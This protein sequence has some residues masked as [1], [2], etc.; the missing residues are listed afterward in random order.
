MTRLLKALLRSPA[1]TMLHAS[2]AVIIAGAIVTALTARDDMVILRQGEPVSVHG[3]ELELTEFRTI[4]YPDGPAPRNYESRLKVNGL[5]RTLAVNAPLTADDWR[6][7]QSSFTPDGCSVIAMRS[8]GPGTAIVFAGYALFALGGFLALVRRR[9]RLTALVAAAAF[10]I[11]A[12]Q[13]VP[14]VTHHA[15]DSLARIPVEYQGRTVTYST[16]AHE[17]MQKITGKKSFRGLSAERVVTS[18]TAFPDEWNAVPLIKSSRGLISFNDCFDAEGNYLL[19]DEPD[20]DE[21]VGIILLL[22]TG[23]LFAPAAEGASLPRADLEIL[24]NRTPSTLVIFIAFFVAAALC[25]MA[26]RARWPRW[27]GALPT[28]MQ[29]GVIAIQC[30]LTGHG[31]FASTFETLQFMVAAVGLLALVLPGSPGPAL[32]A[33]GCMALVAHLQ[34]SNPVVTPLMPVLHSPWLSLHVSLV[35]TSYAMLVVV[36]ATAVCGLLRNPDECRR[37]ARALLRP[38]VYLLGLGI[39]TGSVWA[40]QSWGRYWGWDPKETW[41][42]ITMLVYA[43]PLHRRRPSLWW[44]I[45]PLLSVAMTYFGVNYFHS[46]HAYS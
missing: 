11:G 18:M 3:I 37:R 36:A 34:A 27:L 35:M 19:A 32:L 12:A 9:P 21:R 39:I 31:P 8:D 42:L 26:P 23:S 38:A 5:E 6:L 13:A 45:I 1:L 7:Y 28:V 25:F 16:V 30:V 14:V 44:F 29:V 40:E 41:A 15:A 4:T 2:L 46:L 22:R 33:A 17:V 43:I 20:A 10:G 24:Y